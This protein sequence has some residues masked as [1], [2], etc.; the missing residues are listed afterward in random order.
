MRSKP[1]V[2]LVL[3]ALVLVG[4]LS[5]VSCESC[6]HPAPPPQTTEAVY[7]IFE[8][9]WAIVPDPK[10]ANSILA[11]AP[12]NKSHRPVAVIPANKTLD[13]GI[14]DLSV[15]TRRGAGAPTFDKNLFRATV[16]PQN[17]QRAL[18]TRLE[19]YAIRLPMPEAYL[20]ETHSRSRV[21]PTYPPDPSTEQDYATSVALRYTVTTRAGFSL[22]GTK[23]VGGAFDPELL[24][25][26][27]PVVRFQIE[28]AEDIY[29]DVCY[30]HSR[31][32][33]HDLVRLIGLTL[34]VD[35]PGEGD[36]RKK[37]PQS[38]GSGKAQVFHGMPEQQSAGLFDE[39]ARSIQEAGI[40]IGMLNRYL[41]VAAGKTR[42]AMSA[43][44]F[45]HTGACKA[46]II[47]AI[48][49]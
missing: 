37:D 43:I 8:G 34:Y 1:H 26:G 45:F 13:P 44:F 32:A 5:L 46:P 41:D 38:V 25:L 7:V 3:V 9:P 33:F 14:Y 18:D 22:A 36:C 35:F 42:E 4:T 10:D 17:V 24:D 40:G 16:T 15:P 47:V 39:Q 28:P 23:D 6:E 12:V 49:G 11:L 2:Y 21:G 30:N 27:I 31:H 20:S 29:A 19:R 48:G